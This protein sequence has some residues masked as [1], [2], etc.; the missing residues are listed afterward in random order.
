M[1]NRADD[2]NRVD[3]AIGLPS[4]GGSAWTVRTGTWQVSSNEARESAFVNAAV[5]VLESS[6][7]DVEVQAT[8]TLAG[9]AG[10]VVR[11][12]SA[13]NFLL[14]SG[15]AGT[16]LALAKVAGG[17]QTLVTNSFPATLSSG[18]TIKVIADGD[19]VSCL[20][21]GVEVIPPQTITDY[22]TATK[23]GL[24]GDGQPST[25]FENFSVTDLAAGGGGT[26]TLDATGGSYAIT[27]TTATL[28]A[29]RLLSA[30]AGSYSIT[31]AAAT[32]TY[33]GESTPTFVGSPFASRI[34]GV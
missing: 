17:S 6:A 15:A 5:V 25:K 29:T 33:S 24:Y 1:A 18:D 8:I 2:F 10:I 4:D 3:G 26:Y 23:H 12:A 21:N 7:A 32:L 34:I 11:E 27:G 9:G 30:V 14:A 28:K 31:G 19:Q 16:T 13:G 20:I 22:E